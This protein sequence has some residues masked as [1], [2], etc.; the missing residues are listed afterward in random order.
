MLAAGVNDMRPGFQRLSAQ[1]RTM[2]NE[3]PY[4]RPVSAGCPDM[5]YGLLTRLFDRDTGQ[6]SMIAGGRTTF[7][8]EAA[9]EILSNAADFSRF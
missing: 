8:T 9:A 2:L 5:D 1:V 3:Q 7:G 6:V 4:S